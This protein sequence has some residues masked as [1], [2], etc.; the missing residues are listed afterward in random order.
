[1]K[2]ALQVQGSPPDSMAAQ[3]ALEF[4]EA[5]LAAG[6]SIYRVFFYLGGVTLANELAVVPQDETDL[7]AAWLQLAEVHGFE[8]AVC[9]AAGQRRGLLA[10]AEQARYDKPARSARAGFS[11]VGL[12]QLIDAAVSADRL[13]TF[14]A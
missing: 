5:A 1:M 9:V 13:V 8:L 6:H 3:T 7:A 14:P 12:G 11:I 4:A 10:E 2:F